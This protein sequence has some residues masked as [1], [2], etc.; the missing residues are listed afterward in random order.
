[1]NSLIGLGWDGEGIVVSGDG[2]AEVGR[3]LGIDG[4]FRRHIYNLSFHLDLTKVIQYE[5]TN[6]QKIGLPFHIPLQ[7]HYLNVFSYF[8]CLTENLFLVRHFKVIEN[9]V[10]GDGGSAKVLDGT[11][12]QKD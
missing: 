7:H 4:T 11:V 9:G 5:Y 2:S 3:N 12:L 10:Y 1:M 6:A 8:Y